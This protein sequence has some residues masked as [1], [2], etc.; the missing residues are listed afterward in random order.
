MGCVSHGHPVLCVSLGERERGRGRERELPDGIAVL[1][2][3]PLL[4][5]GLL[6]QRL[7]GVWDEGTGDSAGG[8]GGAV[9]DV[10]GAVG[11]A[12]LEAETH[13]FPSRW[14]TLI[15]AICRFGSRSRF[16]LQPRFWG[17]GWWEIWLLGVYMMYVAVYF[18]LKNFKLS[19]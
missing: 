16:R 15:K 2:V 11:V 4:L 9:L 5:L 8:D 14:I 13:L 6:E 3:I 7:G 19:C 17:S 18:L 1:V 12:A 10:F